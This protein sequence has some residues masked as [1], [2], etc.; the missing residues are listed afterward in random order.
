MQTGLTQSELNQALADIINKHKVKH[1]IGVGNSCRIS[2][3]NFL[4]RM[5]HLSILK[6]PKNF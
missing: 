5:S 6:Q 1:V 3:E 2:E 4:I